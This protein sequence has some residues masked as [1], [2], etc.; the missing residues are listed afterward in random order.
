MLGWSP[1]SGNS[2]DP[3]VLESHACSSCNK[4]LLTAKS[5]CLI[6]GLTC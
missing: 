4:P 5:S 3:S 1:R 6:A 2:Y